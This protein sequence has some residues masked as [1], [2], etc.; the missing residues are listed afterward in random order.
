MYDLQTHTTD[1]GHTSHTK[2]SGHANTYILN[3]KVSVYLLLD[4][5][6]IINT[7]CF[8]STDW[9]TGDREREKR[10]INYLCEPLHEKDNKPAWSPWIWHICS[11]NNTIISKA[12]RS[13]ENTRTLGFKVAV[14]FLH[15]IAFRHNTNTHNERKYTSQTNTTKIVRKYKL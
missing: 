1:S 15:A 10:V 13:S 2:R 14:I 7:R 4:I 11:E 5:T 9:L 12:E 3:I 6:G 8:P